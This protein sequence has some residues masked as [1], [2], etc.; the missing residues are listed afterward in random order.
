MLYVT[1]YI[2]VLVVAFV[3]LAGLCMGS[4]LNC[5][6]LRI[7]SGESIAKGRSKCPTCGHVLSAGDLI[8]LLSWLFLHGKCKY[9]GAKVSARYPIVELVCAVAYVG[10]VLRYDVTLEALELMCFASI[11]V[12]LSLTD[13]DDWLIPNGCIVAAIAVRA[14]YILAVGLQGQDALQLALDSLV[15]GVVVLVPLVIVVLC[16]DKVLGRPS[17]GGGDL[18]LFFVAGLYFGWLQCLLLV[19][20]ACACGLVVAL[21]GGGQRSVDADGTAQG[22]RTSRVIPFGPSIAFACWVVMLCGADVTSWYVGS[23]IG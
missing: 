18:K 15:G 4:F 22:G 20:V 21:A 10:I 7:V 6:A 2:T 5:W 19:I 16:T 23:F 13:I 12:V 8:P 1:P 14:L 9:C 11:L 17:M 3:A